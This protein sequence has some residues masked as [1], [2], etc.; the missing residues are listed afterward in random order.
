MRGLNL[1]DT[2]SIPIPTL[3]RI[4]IGDSWRRI[5]LVFLGT[6]APVPNIG[7]AGEDSGG[8][9]T[10]G[11]STAD[12]AVRAAVAEARFPRPKARTGESNW[13]WGRAGQ[14]ERLPLVL[15]LAAELGRGLVRGVQ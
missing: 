3:L 2:L 9:R 11:A 15:S 5:G 6:A 1:P 12:M 7:A 14:Y 13:K 10:V 8:E 4:R